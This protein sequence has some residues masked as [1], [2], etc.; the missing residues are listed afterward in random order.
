MQEIEQI[1]FNQKSR[2]I[3]N[4]QNFLGKIKWGTDA[5]EY[6]KKIRN[7]WD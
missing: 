4:S 6:Q 7:E 1:L 5:L 2:K 3:F